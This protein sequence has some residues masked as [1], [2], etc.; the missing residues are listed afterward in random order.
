VIRAVPAGE[1]V[2]S[3]VP[4]NLPE[5]RKTQAVRR[6][7]GRDG[8]QRSKTVASI[9]IMTD[10]EGVSGIDCAEMIERDHPRFPG[11]LRAADGGCECGCGGSVRCG[12]PG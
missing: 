3:P 10:L 6:S 5:R 11:V 1:Q 4:E 9:Y 7:A 8:A 12:R 2:R